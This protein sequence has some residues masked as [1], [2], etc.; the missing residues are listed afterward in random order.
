MEIGWRVRGNV[1]L[2]RL[3]GEF[4]LRTAE[5]FRRVADEALENEKVRHVILNLRGVSFLDSSGI[6]AILGRYKRLRKN[7]GVM[8]LVGI[9]PQILPV[10]EISGIIRL[11]PVYDSEAAALG[12]LEGGNGFVGGK[13]VQA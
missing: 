11:L 4:D 13:Q 7:A 5:Q 8:I 10:L 12:A 2:L 1:L 6:G 3:E 9:T